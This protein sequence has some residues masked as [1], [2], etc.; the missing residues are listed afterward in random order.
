MSLFRK[1]YHCPWCMFK[2]WEYWIAQV[3]IRKH[4]RL[5]DIS[6]ST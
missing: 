4:V 3:H 6:V 2:T 5:E 1:T